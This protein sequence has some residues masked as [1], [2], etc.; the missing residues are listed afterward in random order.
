MLFLPTTLQKAPNKIY[1]LTASNSFAWS[2]PVKSEIPF[3]TNKKS[4][5]LKTNDLS[6]L[7]NTYVP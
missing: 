3:S 2:D 5:E 4:F 7:G 6:H 1:T